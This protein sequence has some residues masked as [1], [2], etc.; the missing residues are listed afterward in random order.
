MDIKNCVMTDQYKRIQ[1]AKLKVQNKTFMVYKG[2]N[3]IGRNKAAII[4]LKNLMRPSPSLSGNGDSVVIGN[5]IS[6]A[7]EMSGSEDKS[8]KNIEQ[9]SSVNSAQFMDTITALLQQNS[10]MLKLLQINSSPDSAR[11]DTSSDV[12]NYNVM[13]DLSKS[14]D[15]FNGEGDPHFAVAWLRQLK[16]TANLH[17]WPDAFTLQTAQCHL[18]GAAKYWL[19]GR[20]SEISN[21]SEFEA[22]FRKTFIFEE[23]KNDSWTRMQKRTQR[24]NE[25]I[26]VYF[27]EKLALCK[28]CNLPFLEIKEQISIGLM[29][30]KL[31]DF[32]LTKDHS[33]EDHLFRDI[34]NY[35][36]V[37]NA[38]KGKDKNVVT[39]KVS[40]L[41]TTLHLETET[42]EMTQN[43]TQNFYAATTQ[44]MFNDLSLNQTRLSNLPLQNT[45]NRDTQDIHE[46]ATQVVVYPSTI[47]DRDMETSNV[48]VETVN[49]D[50]HDAPTQIVFF[51][52]QASTSK[53]SRENIPLKNITHSNIVQKNEEDIHTM[54]TQVVLFPPDH[55]RPVEEHEN[56]AEITGN[57]NMH[58]ETEKKHQFPS[59]INENV[60][61]SATLTAEPGSSSKL[62]EG[63]SNP[64][65]LVDDSF[66]NIQKPTNL[67]VIQDSIIE[68][69]VLD[70]KEEN[71][72]KNEDEAVVNENSNDSMDFLTIQDPTNEEIKS[73]DNAD[74]DASTI[75]D[76]DIGQPKKRIPRKLSSSED[77]L[78]TQNNLKTC[79]SDSETDIDIAENIKNTKNKKLHKLNSNGSGQ[80]QTTS[81]KCN[82][83]SETDNEDDL[84]KK[85]NKKRIIIPSD[86][87]T[88]VEDEVLYNHTST[89]TEDII[90]PKK[91]SNVK[92]KKSI[93]S[94]DSETDVED[95]K[96]RESKLEAAQDGDS[97][98]TEIL[99]DTDC[100]PATQDAFADMFQYKNSKLSNSKYGSENVSSEESFKLGLTELMIDG[101]ENNHS[102]REAPKNE[103]KN[104]DEICDEPSTSNTVKT[105]ENEVED[106]YMMPAQ[107]INEV[108]CVKEDE[109]INVMAV[110]RSE[111]DADKL[112][113]KKVNKPRSIASTSKTVT[114]TEDEDLYMLPTQ[115]INDDAKLTSEKFE[116]KKIDVLRSTPSTSKIITEIEKEA[117]DDL[118]MMPTQR[119]VNEFKVPSKKFSFKKKVTN[120]E[121]SLTNI[122]TSK[123]EEDPY[124]MATQK[125]NETEEND[126]DDIYI[127]ATQKLENNLERENKQ[128]I[129]TDEEKNA[130]YMQPTLDLNDI[131]PSASETNANQTQEDLYMA[132][133]QQINQDSVNDLYMLET[134]KLNSQSNLDPVKSA[135]NEPTEKNLYDLPTQPILGTCE[136]D[137]I[138]H[139][140]KE[141]L[142]HTA[143]VHKEKVDTNFS[144][145]CLGK[146]NQDS[147]RRR[148]MTKSDIENLKK[149][150]ESKEKIDDAE[151]LSQIDAFVRNPLDKCER[152][153]DS[154]WKI[155]TVNQ[156]EPLKNV[157]KYGE[158][159]NSKTDKD[160]SQMKGFDQTD[161]ET[162]IK[163]LS[164]SALLKA[165][166]LPNIKNKSLNQEMEDFNRPETL[167]QI[168]AFVKKPVDVDLPNSRKLTK[169]EENPSSSNSKENEIERMKVDFNE[170]KKTT[171]ASRA[172]QAAKPTEKDVYMAPTQQVNQ[173]SVNKK[174]IY[175]SEH[176]NSELYKLETQKI[177]NL[178]NLDTGK[179]VCNKQMEVDLY[180]LPT[181]QLSDTI[182]ADEIQQRN[183]RPS[184]SA[185]VHEG[186]DI[187]KNK[188]MKKSDIEKLK[189]TINSK[190]KTDDREEI[191]RVETLSQIEAFVK[192]PLDVEAPKS[193]KFSV[194]EESTSSDSSR[195]KNNEIK[196]TV[197]KPGKTKDNIIETEKPVKSTRKSRARQPTKFFDEDQAKSKTI[198]KFEST[199]Q[200]K[201]QKPNEKLVEK[202]EARN[203]CT[204][205]NA[206]TSSTDPDTIKSDIDQSFALL[207]AKSTKTRKSRRI[208]N[209]GEI[210]V[211]ACKNRRSMTTSSI[212]EVSK[213]EELKAKPS[214][215]KSRKVSVNNNVASVSE[216]NLG[217]KLKRIAESEESIA[218]KR[219]PASSDSD[220]SEADI[221]MKMLKVSSRKG[222][223]KALVKDDIN[224]VSGASKESCRSEEPATSTS[225]V[226]VS[227]RMASR[228]CESKSN[229]LVKDNIDTISTTSKESIRGK[230]PV[231]P[232][233]SKVRAKSRM[234]SSESNEDSKSYANESSSTRDSFMPTPSRRDPWDFILIDKD[235]ETKWNFSLKESISKA[236]NEQL[237]VNYSFHLLV[238]KATDVL[239]GAIESCGGKCVTRSPA[240]NAEGFYVVVASPENRSK[241]LKIK[242]QNPEVIVV[243]PEAI[244]DGVLRQDLRLGMHLLT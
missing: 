100:I 237:L 230:V 162:S 126:I 47:T 145:E 238:S 149:T 63:S 105:L 244:F 94:S 56:T 135:Y 125:I 220:F 89:K 214:T 141:P 97:N 21:W 65:T 17:S 12:K 229:S 68:E 157:P 128:K 150:V 242:K 55:K 239:K 27:H 194:I 226:R 61:N 91:L 75:S 156:I 124:L 131:A 130:L 171:R 88:D 60:N 45:S 92:P 19:N 199:R 187:P 221:P 177:D 219:K 32:I 153:T 13:P 204:E 25:N 37:H 90:K 159:T 123:D 66:M 175:K 217:E 198:L 185:L 182:D 216:S 208:T 173:D 99:D 6:P 71:R 201:L 5:Q 189:K 7:M 151:T 133:T 211:A 102:I 132:P 142:V 231:T 222:K 44:L 200:T 49:D 152:E 139:G 77:L 210:K 225:K 26:S 181:Q 240:K 227:S 168:E 143:L 205:I 1:G 107:T 28:A 86:S 155:G 147:P 113:L 10:Q 82:S 48:V 223:G 164:D 140:D 195:E 184:P 129:Q 53:A 34:V 209:V 54:A 18:V 74:D 167:S 36:R 178:S 31:S 9:E 24:Q 146:V 93:F 73:N 83:D 190:G 121:G 186:R 2:V 40:N 144:A 192:K 193:R 98:T 158:S 206:S 114:N 172:K 235:A 234:T 136:A 120:L 41:S 183:K 38:R 161:I 16:N 69:S 166:Q 4:N 15:N 57:I 122:L 127:Q 85:T 160:E 202:L 110:Q 196:D 115:K 180:D 176:N 33:D 119:I 11:T 197:K 179:P 64:E 59:Q 108:E 148:R 79:N 23:S 39:N 207:E 188:R 22:A 203:V 174:N 233:T 62:N 218:V 46:A 224:N 80:D 52:P 42:M 111:V 118:Y 163:K 241:F 191:D 154:N 106:L 117:D 101:D 236:A 14:I 95:N 35:E 70:E 84:P 96:E 228:T 112:T 76:S 137:K 81:K 232:S 3:T 104:L 51:S 72:K 213:S 67:T 8:R 30:D 50:I 138:L 29:S 165:K 103:N 20:S 58:A 170:P 169:I 43:A 109:G 212:S 243:E 116:I 215:R 134:Q 87:E 78:P